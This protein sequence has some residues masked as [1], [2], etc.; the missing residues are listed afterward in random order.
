M[1]QVVSTPSVRDQPDIRR[2]VGP[3]ILGAVAA[4]LAVTVTYEPLLSLA[5]V[6]SVGVAIV[7]FK[8]PALALKFML[9]FG[10]IPLEMLGHSDNPTDKPLFRSLGGTTVDGLVLV[11]V[12]LTFMIVLINARPFQLPRGLRFYLAFVAFLA[13]SLSYSSARMDGL[14]LVLKITYPILIFLLALRFLKTKEEINSALRYWIAGGVVATFSGT[15]LYT[16]RGAEA[17]LSWGDFRYSSGLIYYSAFSMYMFSLFVLTYG[18]WRTGGNKAYGALALLFGFQAVATET[19]ITWAAVLVAFLVLE[20][21]KGRG[22]RRLLRVIGMAGVLGLASFYL[23]WHLPQL[24]RRVFGTEDEQPLSPTESL[25]QLNLSSRGELWAALYEDYL[26]HNRLLGQGAGSNMIVIRRGFE[27]GVAA[28]HNEY[29][30]VLHDAGIVGLLLFLAGIVTLFVFFRSL[31][32]TSVRAQQRL[33]VRISL[34][35]LAGYAIMA[36]TDNPFDNYLVFSQFVFFMMALAVAAG[37]KQFTLTGGI[38]SGQ[39]ALAEG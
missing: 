32:R 6:L 23:V 35:L 14:R 28:P 34:A 17:F 7:S 2:F 33:F 15:A 9:L 8:N 18:I 12:S 16:L 37:G 36:I 5:L 4:A 27:E 1:S 25:G 10:G 30:R 20:G 11:M 22:M 39:A 31:L 24:Q 3:S 21:T 19:R 29:L 13:L 38:P 26:A